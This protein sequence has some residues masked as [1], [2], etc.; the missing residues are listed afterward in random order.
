MQD[1]TGKTENHTTAEWVQLSR[2]EVKR[3]DA[4]TGEDLGTLTVELGPQP[5]PSDTAPETDTTDVPF[6]HAANTKAALKKKIIQ[7]SYVNA[8]QPVTKTYEA[9]CKPKR[10]KEVIVNPDRGDTSDG[11][12]K[13]WTYSCSDGEITFRVHFFRNTLVQIVKIVRE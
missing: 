3:W 10:F 2:G 12:N 1:Q 4:K 8:V 5:S 11:K 9:M 6:D 7:I 13:L